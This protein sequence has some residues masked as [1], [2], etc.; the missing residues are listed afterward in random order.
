HLTLSGIRSA[1]VALRNPQAAPA[2]PH[3]FIDGPQECFAAR[4][5]RGDNTMSFSRRRILAAAALGAIL[6]AAFAVEPGRRPT[7]ASEVWARTELYF[8]TNRSNGEPVTESEFNSFI[9]SQ[10]T[11]RFP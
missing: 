1:P 6:P 4:G 8:G 9:E 3:Y 11:E 7:S 2:V 5:G 10:V